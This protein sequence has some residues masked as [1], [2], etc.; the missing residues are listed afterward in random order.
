MLMPDIFTDPLLA[1]A[2]RAVADDLGY[3]NRT[4]TAGRVV[5]LSGL[6]FLAT[7]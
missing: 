5:V 4:G 3:R 7:Q 1:E 2:M 6:V